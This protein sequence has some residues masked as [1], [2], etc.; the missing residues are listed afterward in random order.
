MEN[1]AVFR[2][3]HNFPHAP[4]CGNP[5]ASSLLAFFR[6]GRG[7]ALIL[8]NDFRLWVLLLHIARKSNCPFHDFGAKNWGRFSALKMGSFF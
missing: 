6:A 5:S 4:F 2:L 8:A 1:H 7:A 3:W